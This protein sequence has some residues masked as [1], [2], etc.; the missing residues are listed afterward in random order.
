MKI[1]EV[2][3]KLNISPRAVRFYEHKGLLSPSKHPDNQYRTFTDKDIWRLQTIISLREAGM[4]ISDI[5]QALE[6]WDEDDKEEL[7]YYLELQRSVM[8]SEWLQI[9]QAIETTEHMIQLLKTEQSLPLEHIF[10]LAEAS[11]KRREH[12]GNWEDR[13]NFNQLATTH[14]E[15]VSA[16]SGNYADYDQALDLIVRQIRPIDN[17]QGLDIGTGTGNLAVRFMDLGHTMSGVDQSK[18]MLRLCHKK[19]PSLE[20]RLG[21]FLALPYLEEQF[22][23]VVSSFAFHH[24]TPDQQPLALEEIGRVLKPSGRICIADLMESNNGSKESSPDYPSIHS[25]VDWFERNGYNSVVTPVNKRL[26]L[27]YA[28]KDEQH[29]V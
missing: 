25:L 12:R 7:Q 19:H 24:L 23:F 10:Q 21:N 5:K 3:N 16:N 29:L 1:K 22:D 26:H 9:K 2:T 28:S 11:K 17:E 27:I 4:S 8:M 18:E 13:W 6:S 15:R 20:T 14:D